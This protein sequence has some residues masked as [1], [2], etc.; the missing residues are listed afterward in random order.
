MIAEYGDV[1]FLFSP[2]I[3]CPSCA[4]VLLTYINV[5]RQVSV[6]MKLTIFFVSSGKYYIIQRPGMKVE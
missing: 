4:I 3:R 6:K 1:Q 5:V 2:T